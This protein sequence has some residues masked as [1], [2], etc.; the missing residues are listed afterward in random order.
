M[1]LQTVNK[2]SLN[3]AN[4]DELV[5]NLYPQ[6]KVLEE[7]TTSDINGGDTII[8][9]GE[10]KTVCGKDIHNDPL[11]GVSIFGDAFLYSRRKVIKA[12]F[13]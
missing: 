9:R 13:R 3:Q 10:L 11:M 1:T 7:V 5:K 6:P 12:T 4:F 8:H 2:T